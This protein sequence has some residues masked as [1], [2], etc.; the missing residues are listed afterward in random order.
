MHRW[1]AQLTEVRRFEEMMAAPVAEW[2]HRGLR[3]RER[4][5]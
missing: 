1:I 4:M 5:Q 2:F 3:L